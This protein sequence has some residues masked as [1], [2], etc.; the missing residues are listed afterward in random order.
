MKNRARRG[1][2]FILALLMITAGF[3]LSSYAKQASKG[4]NGSQILGW[5]CESGKVF[6]RTPSMCSK[7][8]G[9]F[10]KDKKAAET[11]IDA[12]TPGWC[13][14]NNTAASMKKS[15]CQKR[16]GHFFIDKNTAASWCD[17]HTTGF[18]CLDGHVLSMEKGLCLQKKGTFSKNRQK[19]ESV[20][21]I[22]GWCVLK[23]RA[24]AATKK[25]C[26]LKKG[27]FFTRK[28][29]AARA[30]RTA[31][32][33]GK[34]TPAITGKTTP[35]PI[36][37]PL[38]SVERITLKNGTIHI[39]IKNK[40]KG[41]ITRQ[42]YGRGTLS[43]KTGRISRRWPL[44]KVD[45][46][47]G[48]N[49]GKAVFFDTK[50]KLLTQATVQA[51]FSLV[52]S[53]KF[54]SARLTPPIIINA[55]KASP[56]GKA[57]RAPSMMLAG[58]VK[59]KTPAHSPV[60][61]ELV[62]GIH[63]LNPVG[64]GKYYQG[65]TL[66]ILYRITDEDVTSGSITFTVT[67]RTSTVG[68]ATVPVTSRRVGGPVPLTLRENTPIGR[69]AVIAQHSA[70][71]SP[72]YGE[73]NEFE[74]T[75]N[76]ARIDFSAPARGEVFHRNGTI[77]VRYKFNRRVEPGTVTF[78]LYHAGTVIAT[79]T[80][81]HHP[82]PAN[83]QEITYTFNF[84]VPPESPDG[85]YTLFATHPRATGFTPRFAVA[86][87]GE[88]GT[89][90]AAAWEIHSRS[91]AGGSYPRGSTQ[92]LSWVLHG[93]YPAERNFIVQLM[94]G[95]E[96]VQTIPSDRAVWHGPSKSYG[97]DW[98]VPA[99]LEPGSDY[100]LKIADRNSPVEWTSRYFQITG[101]IEVLGGGGTRY[102]ANR[103]VIRYRIQPNSGIHH[104]RIAVVDRSGNEVMGI[105]NNL[106]A[107][108]SSSVREYSF[109][110]GLG[111]N[112]KD[113]SVWYYDAEI[114]S[115][116]HGG[117]DYAF[118]VMDASDHSIYGQ[119]MYFTVLY[120]GIRVRTTKDGRN[121]VQIHWEGDGLDGSAR[122]NI[123]CIF[124]G[125]VAGGGAD[126]YAW[127][128]VRAIMTNA[129]PIP[130]SSHQPVSGNFHWRFGETSQPPYPYCSRFK[131]VSENPARIVAYPA[132]FGALIYG[133][134]NLF[135]LSTHGCRWGNGATPL[136]PSHH[137]GSGRLD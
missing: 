94:R 34:T 121:A 21:A 105:S 100:R 13:C 52:P 128:P 2:I 67:D 38:L 95:T 1:I 120:P 15:D 127:V 119:G 48:L 106:Y 88:G 78:Q 3:A 37:S 35:A 9:H 137:S 79:Q 108:S 87:I 130:I 75:R 63:I 54:K 89:G 42:H 109:E 103:A 61:M 64:G 118:R 28:T 22:H 133:V 69:Y 56:P 84:E 129:C 18:C 73:S 49:Q 83:R 44:A 132:G 110:W 70:S 102:L 135:D 92:P 111:A 131:N 40:G 27:R 91:L 29:E 62:R 19:A 26:R 125:D 8:K 24:F 33:S 17:L 58:K 81:E 25:A 123:F 124:V 98:H 96:I 99:D 23:G 53:G 4:T 32:G 97:L 101:P 20:C 136:R 50:V 72:A 113:G 80:R 90:T 68:T 57:R 43:L 82:A 60:P 5:C 104:V 114:G 55:H 16:K 51:G 30:A 14:L 122:I 74:V 10:F 59:P 134:S 116:L 36:V 46:G 39:L 77:P 76:S 93:E 6:R 117:H 7:H 126:N 41:K 47:K 65:E 86:S 85:D 66:Y 115:P 107:E 31:T 45:P 71:E 112:G 12:Q 11:W